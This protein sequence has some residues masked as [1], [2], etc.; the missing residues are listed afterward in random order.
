MSSRLRYQALRGLRRSFSLVLPSSRSQ[1]HLDVFGGERFAVMPLDPLA[2]PEAY[3]RV[4]VVPFPALGQLGLDQIEPVLLF[5]LLEEDEVVEHPHEGRNRRDRRLLMD[6]AARR[7][8]A[9][10]EFEDTAGLLRH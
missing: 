5:V 2:E 7:A 3:P 9:V 1:V 6:R 4:V 10:K 8:V